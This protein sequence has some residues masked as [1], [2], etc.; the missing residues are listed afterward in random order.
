[1]AYSFKEKEIDS[2]RKVLL[3]TSNLS[4]CSVRFVFRYHN[5]GAAHEQLSSAVSAPSVRVTV[6]YRHVVRSSDD[7]YLVARRA[8]VKILG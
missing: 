6:V 3:R 2:E 5:V 7:G 4:A 1:M 8:L